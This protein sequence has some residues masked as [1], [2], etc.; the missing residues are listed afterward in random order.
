[1]LQNRSSRQIWNGKKWVLQRKY[2]NGPKDY[3][4]LEDYVAV[5]FLDKWDRR[6]LKDTD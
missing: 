6:K 3:E 2:G 4:I 1:M 5:D